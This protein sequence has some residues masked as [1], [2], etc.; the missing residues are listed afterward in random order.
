MEHDDDTMQFLFFGDDE[1]FAPQRRSSGARSSADA[2][3]SD[4]TVEPM[5]IWSGDA[6]ETECALE[7]MYIPTE[8]LATRIPPEEE[9]QG[10]E[11]AAP[12]DGSRKTRPGK[13]RR[14]RIK[15]LINVHDGY[16][17]LD[18]FPNSHRTG[19]YYRKVN[20]SVPWKVKARGVSPG[21]P[22]SFAHAADRI[23]DSRRVEC[24]VAPWN[25]CLASSLTS[26]FSSSTSLAVGSMAGNALASAAFL[27]AFLDTASP[28]RQDAGREERHDDGEDDGGRQKRHTSISAIVCPDTA[29]PPRESEGS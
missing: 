5:Y 20:L 28:V 3:Q 9:D 26:D 4:T 11:T 8:L 10:D 24:V 17:P 23:P 16:A 7:P 12:K 18:R 27:D 22:A 6:C 19:I 15:K 21:P 29:S 14:D 25:D 1:D 2:L 13:R